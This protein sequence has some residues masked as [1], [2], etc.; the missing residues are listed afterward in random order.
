MIE[1][2]SSLHHFKAEKKLHYTS[3]LLFDSSRF[4]GEERDDDNA[5]RKP[6]KK[7]GNF[8]LFPFSK[9]DR[10]VRVKKSGH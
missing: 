8:F 2:E 7:M 5:S 9:E 10:P 6:S 3:L 1:K 4:E